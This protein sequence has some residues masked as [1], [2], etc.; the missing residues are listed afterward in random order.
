M[1]ATSEKKHK[2][3]ITLSDEDFSMLEKI[4]Q[5]KC[6]RRNKSQQIGWLIK[7]ENE[8]LQEQER[9]KTPAEI[10]EGI[11]AYVSQME[12]KMA[13]NAA[14]YVPPCHDTR[15]IQFPVRFLGNALG[16]A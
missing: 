5:L 7:Q 11:R 4:R 8:R 3:A 12:K 14:D 1:K 13:K 6:N 2:I 10:R 9:E 15:I 16:S